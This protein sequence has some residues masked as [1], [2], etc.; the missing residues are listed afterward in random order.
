M[1]FT[2][3]PFSGGEPLDPISNLLD[4]AGELMPHHHRNSIRRKSVVKDIDVAPAN[5][6]VPDLHQYFAF[7]SLRLW[8][9]YKIYETIAAPFL[10]NGLQTILRGTPFTKGCSR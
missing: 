3:D 10:H 8:N 4:S 1:R 7:F 6:G 9:L 5:S 2:D